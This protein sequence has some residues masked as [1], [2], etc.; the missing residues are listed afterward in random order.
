MLKLLR[1]FELLDF[2]SNE[3]FIEI[4]KKNEIKQSIHC[5]LIKNFHRHHHEI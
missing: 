1:N 5:F 4:D 3:P 2:G